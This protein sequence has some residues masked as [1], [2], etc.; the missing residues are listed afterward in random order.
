MARALVFPASKTKEIVTADP[1]VREVSKQAIEVIRNAAQL[2]ANHLFTK[3][4]DEARSR[5]RVTLNM[6]DF[7]AVVTREDALQ[8]MLGQF[9]RTRGA[10]GQREPSEDDGRETE[11][12][13]QEE[14]ADEPDDA[15]SKSEIDD[16]LR[17]DSEEESEHELH[18]S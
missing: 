8:A 4:A 15:E 16:I 18:S 3:C 11:S 7:I 10:A 17:E 1:D 6:R 13:E 12:D 5:K 2:F 14:D 9:I